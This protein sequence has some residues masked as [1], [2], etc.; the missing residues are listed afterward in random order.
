MAAPQPP[1]TFVP[2]SDRQKKPAIPAIQTN[3]IADRRLV[4]ILQPIK[5]NVEMLTGVR[6][7]R[8]EQLDNT[9][10]LDD[11]IEKLNEVIARINF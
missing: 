5:Q 2:I 1:R 8:V 6:G 7:G 10:T 4:S 3:S 11:V 9:A